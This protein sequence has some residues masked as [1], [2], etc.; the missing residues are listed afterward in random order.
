MPV[1][2]RAASK[3]VAPMTLLA[4][5]WVTSCAYAWFQGLMYGARTALYMDVSNPAVAATQF[6]AY[7]AMLNVVIAYS[8]AWQ[9]NRVEHWGYPL[10]LTVDAAAGLVCLAV[11]PLVRK[12]AP[13]AGP[14]PTDSPAAGAG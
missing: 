14:V 7:M 13:L 9:G 3:P 10:T 8:A 2:P 6:T 4:F 12:P 11:L 1:D 5:F